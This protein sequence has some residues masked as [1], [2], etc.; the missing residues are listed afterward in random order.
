MSPQIHGVSTSKDTKNESDP[1]PLADSGRELVF[2][3]WRAIRISY[4]S[5]PKN[6]RPAN[7]DMSLTRKDGLT[8]VTILH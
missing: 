2:Q 5:F 8:T 1:T 4:S 3:S 6:K 7:Y